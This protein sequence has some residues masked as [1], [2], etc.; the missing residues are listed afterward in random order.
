MG[1]VSD[2]TP[3]SGVIPL[4]Q[5]SQ[6]DGQPLL[7]HGIGLIQLLKANRDD[8]VLQTHL[9]RKG[10]EWTNVIGKEGKMPAKRKE[11]SHNLP[12]PT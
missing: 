9:L 1:T 10:R 3:A 4:P 5:P 8:V 12:C 11:P 6:A 2:T 7:E